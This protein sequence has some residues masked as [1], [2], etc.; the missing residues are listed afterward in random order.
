MFCKYCGAEIDDNSLFCLKCGKKLN[1][2]IAITNENKDQIIDENAKEKVLINNTLEKQI[3][4]SNKA[5]KIIAIILVFVFA[6]VITAIPIVKHYNNEVLDNQL[7]NL[8]SSNACFIDSIR[9]V[10]NNTF[11]IDFSQDAIWDNKS[12]KN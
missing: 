12:V 3:Q 2:N 7:E 8:E 10:N 1:S 9:L 6:S 5:L 11:K 4:K